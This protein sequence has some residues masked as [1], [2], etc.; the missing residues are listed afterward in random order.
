[1]AEL[2]FQRCS[3]HQV[4]D[5]KRLEDGEDLNDAL[6]DFFVKLG[7]SLI[8]CGGLEGGYPSVAYLGSLFYD[9]LRKGGV[10][11]GRAGYANVANWAKRRLGDGGLFF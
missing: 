11:D 6:M 5:V 10:K 8:P 9:V 7:Q 1:M 2:F 3:V 4:H